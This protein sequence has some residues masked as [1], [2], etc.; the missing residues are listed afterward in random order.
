MQGCMTDPTVP[1]TVNSLKQFL[2]LA[3]VWQGAVPVMQ[4]SDLA[5]LQE[6]EIGDS[7][8]PGQRISIGGQLVG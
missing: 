8:Q 4:R 1:G 5:H 7:K 3:I 6:V 2:G